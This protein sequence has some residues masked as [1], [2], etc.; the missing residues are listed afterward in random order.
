MYQFV[1]H[2]D[3]FMRK[4][5]VCQFATPLSDYIHTKPEV[6]SPQVQVVAAAVELCRS[7]GGGS[8]FDDGVIILRFFLIYFLQCQLTVHS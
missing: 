5:V 3:I 7:N 1:A 4:S 6:S 8:A 2:P